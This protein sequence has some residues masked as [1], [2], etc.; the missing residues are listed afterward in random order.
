[1]KKEIKI[2][3]TK[4]DI[5]ISGTKADIMTLITSLLK[6]LRVEKVLTEE[7]IKMCVELSG[8]TEKE[9]AQM[10]MEKIKKMI[11]KMGDE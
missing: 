10:A 1:M 9:L 8:K 3:V 6:N 7:D 2:I 5:E 4:D 11:E